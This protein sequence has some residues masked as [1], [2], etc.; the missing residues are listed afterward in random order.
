MNT[1]ITSNIQSDRIKGDFLHMVFFWLKNPND[2]KDRQSFENVLKEFISTNPQVV[3]FH[4]GRPAETNRPV[5]DFSYTYSLVVSFPDLK[6]HDAYQADPSHLL[7]I[8]KAQHLWNKV[9]IY[10]SVSE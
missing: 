9:Q 3:S 5:V 8:E 4:I 6:T 7:F 1:F 2:Q 10:D